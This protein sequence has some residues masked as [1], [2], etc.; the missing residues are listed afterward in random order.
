MLWVDVN[1]LHALRAMFLPHL[2][3][4]NAQPRAFVISAAGDN[5]RAGRGRRAKRI[6]CAALSAS[7]RCRSGMLLPLRRAH[8]ALAA[9][10]KQNITLI[11]L[12][13]AAS[14]VRCMRTASHRA[15]Y[16]SW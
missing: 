4:V 5:G 16:L 10:Y 6:A 11:I 2:L 9:P 13:G 3:R 15:G 7:R 8:C 1:P 12:A 14:A